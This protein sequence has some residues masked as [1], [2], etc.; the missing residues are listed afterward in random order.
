[1][2]SEASLRVLFTTA[3]F[4]ARPITA[5]VDF[6]CQDLSELSNMSFKD[7]DVG[8]NNIHKSMA[9][10]PANTCVR[11]NVSKC[12]ILHSIRLHFYDRACC[13]STLDAGNITALLASDI[14]SMKE[15]Y[16]ESLLTRMTTGL[17][18]VKLPKL[19]H[20]KWP[21]FKSSLFEPAHNTCKRWGWF[22]WRL[23]WSP[24][25]I[26]IMHSTQGRCVQSR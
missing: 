19:T 13:A 3:G 17:G 5:I 6:L 4:G 21:K 14:S 8:I 24:H 11:L 7:L 20:L 23:W 15:K 18:E 25:Q 12:I 2:D 16:A 22:W 10:L 1:M 9:T 26:D